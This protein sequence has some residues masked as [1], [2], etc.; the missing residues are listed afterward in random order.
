MASS[1]TR[2]RHKDN[3]RVLSIRQPYAWLIAHGYK[4]EEYRTWSTNYRGPLLIHASLTRTQVERDFYDR[5]KREAPEMPP[6]N[7]LER[8]GIVGVCTVVGCTGT[9]GAYAWQLAN[10]R[11]VP[12]VE[13]KGKLSLAKVTKPELLALLTTGERAFVAPT[14]PPGPPA[15]RFRRLGPAASKPK[16]AGLSRY[17]R[18]R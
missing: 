13:E 11:S 2:T 16:K 10:P 4:P 14:E 9:D 12:F 15:P 17:G 7:E 3:C 1:K 5:A 6:F 18:G 8:G